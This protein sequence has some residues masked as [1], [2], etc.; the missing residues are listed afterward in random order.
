MKVLI[1]KN[2]SFFV[3]GPFFIALAPLG[4]KTCRHSPMGIFL[5]CGFVAF[6]LEDGLIPCV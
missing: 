4:E 3:V 6:L 1:I 2:V 5:S